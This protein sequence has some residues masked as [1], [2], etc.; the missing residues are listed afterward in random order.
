[1]DM[2]V[3]QFKK[4][5]A[6]GKTLYGCWLGIPDPTVAELAAGAGFDWVLIDHEHAPFEFSDVMSHL[7]AMAPYPCSVLA[8]PVNDD[9][10]LLKKFLEMGAQNFVVPMIDTAEQAKACAEALR[11][12]PE[13]KRGVGTS[14]A[15][16]ARWNQVTG[17]LQ[18][19]NEQMF[20][21]VQAE[22]VESLENLDA[23]LAVEGVDAVFVGPS[24][25]AASMGHIGNAG[26]PDVV[27]AIHTALKKIRAAGKAAGILTLDKG[28][29]VEF[30]AAGANF[31]GVGVDTLLLG[32]ALRGLAAEF[33]KA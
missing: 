6:D 8:R 20:L 30:S 26:H 2:P 33:V 13:G 15:R 21:A 19:A 16:A 7:R 5:L 22:T 28:K 12:P 24:D 18:K 1:M 32:N 25:L 27:E 23:I 29:I 17:Y 11:Y 3:N 31:V 9:P 14:L 4:D 10:A